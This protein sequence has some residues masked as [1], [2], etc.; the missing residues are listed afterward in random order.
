MKLSFSFALLSSAVILSLSA[1]AAPIRD[2]KNQIPLPK[3]GLD[4]R[5]DAFNNLPK[6]E[7]NSRDVVLTKRRDAYNDAPKP[8]TNSR[9]VVLTKRRDDKNES[10]S[11]GTSP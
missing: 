1:A 11:S 2:D 6:P 4:K 5:R 10:K 7:V 3:V 8:K 9:S